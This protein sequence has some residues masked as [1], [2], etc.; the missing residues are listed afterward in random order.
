MSTKKELEDEVK[1]LKSI[2]RQLKT[3]VKNGAASTEELT[4]RAFALSEDKLSLVLIGY[5]EK[6]NSAAILDVKKLHDDPQV[7]EH[8]MKQ[9]QSFN[10]RGL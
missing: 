8:M 3:E 5:N 4:Q 7:A 6:K 1:N 9:E 10:L 2:I